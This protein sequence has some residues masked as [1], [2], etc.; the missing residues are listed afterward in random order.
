M[1]KCGTPLPHKNRVGKIDELL[2]N[3]QEGSTLKELCENSGFNKDFVQNHF[4]HLKRTHGIPIIR[5]NGLYKINMEIFCQTPIVI[6]TSNLQLDPEI[7]DQTEV[8]EIIPSEVQLE[9]VTIEPIL[10]HSDLEESILTGSKFE[11]QIVEETLLPEATI[12]PTSTD[13]KLDISL[14]SGESDVVPSF[15][16]AIIVEPIVKIISK[17]KSRKAA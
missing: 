14:S 4:H 8:L 9:E 17:K 7:I 3:N 16:E 2:I 10:I 1:S 13:I 11:V 6:S 5:V 12:E 15:Q